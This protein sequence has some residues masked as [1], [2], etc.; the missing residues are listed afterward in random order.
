MDFVERRR[1]EAEMQLQH[2]SMRESR[3][4]GN[5]SIKLRRRNNGSGGRLTR[6]L[7]LVVNRPAGV[8]SMEAGE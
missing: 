7:L 4:V 8:M 1:S 2:N 6:N 3:A 5:Y